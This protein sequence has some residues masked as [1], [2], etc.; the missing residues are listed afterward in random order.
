MLSLIGEDF[1]QEV[2]LKSYIVRIYRHGE[3]KPGKFI[4]T[5]EEPHLKQKKA[6][7]NFDELWEILNPGTCTGIQGKETLPEETE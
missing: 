3:G 6:F 7:T 4:G 2:N 5:V 1:S